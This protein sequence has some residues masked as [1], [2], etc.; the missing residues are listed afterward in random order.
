MGFLKAIINPLINVIAAPIRLMWFVPLAAIGLIGFT[1]FNLL[2]FLFKLFS[3]DLNNYLMF[4]LLPGQSYSQFSVARPWYQ[5]LII[6]FIL[7]LINFLC[8]LLGIQKNLM[9]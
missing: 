7:W 4:N 1:I 2:F 6:S 5:F 3:L 8:L 9:D